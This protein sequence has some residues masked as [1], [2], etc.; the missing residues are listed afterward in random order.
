MELGGEIIKSIY[1][2]IPWQPSDQNSLSLL[3]SDSSPGQGTKILP[4][5]IKKKI[6]TSNNEVF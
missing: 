4:A 6:S 1:A 3:G 2:G 5:P